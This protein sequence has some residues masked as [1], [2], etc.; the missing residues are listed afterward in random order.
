M[1]QMKIKMLIDIIITLDPKANII[2]SNL[3][4]Y[5]D[6]D[7]PNNHNQDLSKD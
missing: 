2:K 6:T 1:A 3:A 5:K 4:R 7:N